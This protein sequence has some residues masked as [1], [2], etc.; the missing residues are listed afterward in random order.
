MG[1][2]D[3]ENP[4]ENVPWMFY[5]KYKPREKLAKPQEDVLLSLREKLK[6]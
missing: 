4:P 5:K 2:K 6:I 3:T 1:K